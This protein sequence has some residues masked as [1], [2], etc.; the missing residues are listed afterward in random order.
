MQPVSNK[1]FKSP[2]MIEIKPT[3]KHEKMLPTWEDVIYQRLEECMR[4]L[5][6]NGTLIFK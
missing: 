2:Y 4:V 3:K 6:P 5:K 1:I